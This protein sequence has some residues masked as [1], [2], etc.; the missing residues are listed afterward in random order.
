MLLDTNALIWWR[1]GSPRLGPKA[2][3]KL[4]KASALYFSSVSILE[5]EI[6]RMKREVPVGFD[7]Y[8]DLIESGF[9]EVRLS[10]VE[11]KG[12][13]NY[14][15]L[16]NHDPFDRVLLATAESSGMNFVTA[17]IQILNLELPFVIDAQN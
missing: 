1:L 16:A 9:Q 5:L 4:E 7:F 11:A 6:K 15:S 12:L 13:R 17:D 10:G 14:P 8:E 2:L 3:N